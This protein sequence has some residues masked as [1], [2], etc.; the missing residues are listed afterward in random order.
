MPSTGLEKQTKSRIRQWVRSVILIAIILVIAWFVVVPQYSEASGELKSFRGVSPLLLVVAALFEICSLVSFSLLTAI[1][2]GRNRP[3]F[4]TIFRIDLTDLGISHVIP[5]GGTA[6]AAVRFRLLKEA[7]VSSTRALTTASIEIIISNLML[8][9][10]FLGGIFLSVTSL[11]YNN[12]YVLAT[13]IVG[14]ILMLAIVLFWLLVWQTQFVIDTVLS[15]ARRFSDENKV[16]ATNYITTMSNE[17]NGFRKTPKRLIIICVLGVL[18]WL[19]DAFALW[20]VL[21][22]LGYPLYIGNL[23]IA[24][25]IAS[26][27]S[28]LPLT[29]GGIGIMEGVLVPS[30]VGF[31]VPGS[32][33]LVGVVGWRVLEFWLPI[34]VSLVSY[35]SLKISK[36]KK[37]H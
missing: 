16:K 23:L 9:F 15:L 7:R 12:Y 5:G 4:F 29:P 32:V 1:I 34:P 21:A 2:L 18:N 6:A 36:F 10:V 11:A 30:L 19:L 13:V 28:L 14:V 3:D 27:L 20:L 33:A 35:I 17:F 37:A 22:A 31:G 25:G 8:G 26:I 24:Y